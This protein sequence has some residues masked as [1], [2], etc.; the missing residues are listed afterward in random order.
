MK[1]LRTP[2][3]SL[4][5]I[6]VLACVTAFLLMLLTISGSN[7]RRRNNR[8][9]RFLLWAAYTLTSYLIVYTLG[10]M[11]EAS[12]R[13]E[14][15]PVWATFL[16][17]FFGSSDTYSVHSLEDC[18]RWKNYVWQYALKIAGVSFL[19]IMS[20]IAL[21]MISVLTLCLIVPLKV[22]RRATSLKIA[23]GSGRQLTGKSIADY[24]QSEHQLSEGDLDPSQMRGYR[25]VV[26]KGKTIPMSLKKLKEREAAKQWEAPNYRK[27]LEITDRVVTIEK[28]WKCQGWLLRSGG[29]DKDSK[30]KDICLSFSLYKLLRLEFSDYSLPKQA[31]EKAWKLIRY[32]YAE[33]NGYERAFRVVELELSFLF[34]SFYTSYPTIFKP[35]GW[36]LKVVELLLLVI[37]VP[38]TIGLCFPRYDSNRPQDEVQLATTGGLS[39]DFLVTVL[40]LLIF[41]WVE[42]VQCFFMAISDWA[43][44][45]LLC[46]YVRTNSWHENR[47]LEK[48]IRLICRT[49]LPKPW[50]RKL[51]QYSLLESYDY[52]PPRWL[53]N[54]I[55][56]LFIDRIRDGQAQS[57]PAELSAEVKKAVFRSL[58]SNPEAEAL[59]N[60]VSSLIRNE[61]EHEL[62]WACRLDTQTQVIIVWHIATS[63]LEHR[64]RISDS[65]FIVA[66]SLSKYLAYL[67]TF[68]PKLLFD[69]PY[70]SEYIFNVIVMEARRLLKDCKTIGERINKLNRI[71]K[72]TNVTNKVIIQGARLGQQLL[73]VENEPNFIWKVL[74]EFWAELMVYVAP[75]NNAIAHAQHLARGGEFVT[76]LWA[77][78]SHA[79]IKRENPVE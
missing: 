15:L 74:A 36:R 72:T 24:M 71:H 13:N 41:A 44:V 19:F 48:L 7:R 26:R 14:L 16:M 77:L 78:V 18:E 34:D 21:P 75:S 65:N 20:G 6:E 69:Q 52:T 61:V 43:K 79:G 49:Q 33:G 38:V 9:L 63:M 31:H 68:Y 25:Y 28:V 17:I 40:I 70:D 46:K 5:K 39:I 50:E 42:L 12:F 30:L 76:H 55:T 62:A 22:I 3:A 11:T 58:M 10:L 64:V 23:S 57:S 59:K 37:G 67:V 27:P 8:K 47:R 53:Y 66:T 35:L 2:K 60:G 45:A 73:D 51:Q 4:A 1:S 54:R 56:Y 32:L 29:G